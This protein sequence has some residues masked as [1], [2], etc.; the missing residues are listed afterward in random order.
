LPDTRDDQPDPSDREDVPQPAAADVV[1]DTIP[2]LTPA[3]ALVAACDL[4]V[5]RALERA[6]R[7]VLNKLPRQN[8]ALTRRVGATDCPAVRLHTCVHLDQYLPVDK[9]LDGAWERLGETADRLGEDGPALEATLT[10]YVGVL[11]RTQ[12]EHTWEGLAR[13]LGVCPCEVTS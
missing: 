1:P 2:G 7:R 13:A 3:I 8:G 9:L 5:H 10:A 6:G 4:L 12:T 11:V